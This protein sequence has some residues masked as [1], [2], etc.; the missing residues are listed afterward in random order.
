MADTTIDN[1]ADELTVVPADAVFEG[2]R[3]AGGDSFKVQAANM[4]GGGGGYTTLEITTNSAVPYDVPNDGNYVIVVTTDGSGAEQIVNLTYPAALPNSGIYTQNYAVII[5][6]ETLTNVADILKV[7]RG[8]SVDGSVYT[9]NSTGSM[10]GNYS[11]SELTIPVFEVVKFVLGQGNWFLDPDFGSQAGAVWMPSNNYLTARGDLNLSAANGLDGNDPG[12]NINIQG[13]F[14]VGSG[15]GGSVT[16]TS[17]AADNADG[18]SLALDGAHANVGGNAHLLAGANSGGP[19]GYVELHAGNTAQTDGTG[20]SVL[21]TAGNG[22]GI[23]LGGVVAANVDND[24]FFDAGDH[25]ANN[26]GYLLARVKTVATLPDATLNTDAVAI[27]TDATAPAIGA[28]V[29]GG[30]TVRCVVNS[31][32]VDWRVG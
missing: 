26:A 31:D 18:A 1:I 2:Q 14:P 24:S 5:V 13:G 12:Y 17:G 19:G 20:G 9:A 28:I 22:N 21:L 30:G 3:A 23:G 10:Y 16:V 6:C 4:P 8:A 32:G 11:Y 27:V 29:V 25:F 7:T 15:N